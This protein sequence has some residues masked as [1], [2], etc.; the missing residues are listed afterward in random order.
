MDRMYSIERASGSRRSPISTKADAAGMGE[1]RPTHVY[2]LDTD[3]SQP[4]DSVR[5]AE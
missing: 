1:C 3:T 5:V 2:D 4:F